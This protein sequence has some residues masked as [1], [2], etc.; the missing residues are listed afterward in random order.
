MQGVT[1]QK[2]GI[3][4]LSCRFII[5]NI[6]MMNIYQSNSMGQ[7]KFWETDSRSSSPILSWNLNV[8]YPVHKGQPLVPILG[9][10][11]PVHTLTPYLYKLQFNINLP[12]TLT[13]NDHSGRA[14]E[15]WDRGFESHS[16]HGC[17]SAFI[18]CLCCP[19][20]LR[21][22]DGLIPRERSPTAVYRNKYRW[23]DR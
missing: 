10:T 22:C 19:R 21:L 4:L 11:N 5:L 16:R 17:L 1:S 15:H 6:P 12:S 2:T 18:L 23:M 8:H 13:R 3:L 14:L 9:Q 7:S 20:K